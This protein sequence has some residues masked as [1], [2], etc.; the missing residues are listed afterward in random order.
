[1]VFIIVMIYALEKRTMGV[2]N[3]IL[4]TAIGTSEIHNFGLVRYTLLIIN[5][6]GGA[7]FITLSDFASILEIVLDI[8]FIFPF[9]N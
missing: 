3:S 1:M 8:N 6:Q 7:K 4:L 9:V 5:I 2:F